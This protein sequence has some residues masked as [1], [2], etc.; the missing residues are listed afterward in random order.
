MILRKSIFAPVV[1]ASLALASVA[2]ASEPDSPSSV[3][4]QGDD[5]KPGPGFG[6]RV[7]GY[8]FRGEDGKWA[9]CR[10]G[11]LGLFGTY[12]LTRHFFLEAGLDSYQA[13]KSEGE[14]MDRISVLTSVAGGLRMFPDFYATPYVQIGT[15]AEWT[16]VEIMGE[17]T[18]GLYPMAFLGIGAEL[19]LLRSFRVG[20]VLRTL[21][22]A[23]PK[24]DEHSMGPVFVPGQ[25]ATMEYVP[26]SQGQFYLRYV[27]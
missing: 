14:G 17:R 9:D 27:L 4:N 19:N 3:W 12:D 10:M 2:S 22:M 11:G 25:K 24:H 23:H 13:V 20:A 26:S 8:A 21:A 18:E 7:G 16:R 5:A 6:A 15:G 1:I